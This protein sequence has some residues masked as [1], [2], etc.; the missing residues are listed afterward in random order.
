MPN[1]LV[2]TKNKKI[3]VLQVLALPVVIFLSALVAFFAF[4]LNVS[5]NN[6]NST[7]SLAVYLPRAEAGN[8]R[9][10]KDF[11]SVDVMKLTK[12]VV[13]NQPS[14]SQINSIVAALAQ[15][16]LKYIAISVPMDATADYPAGEKP[17][18]QTAEVFTREWADAIHNHG[19][20]VMWRGTF[21]GLEG[22]Y[23][24]KQLVGPNRIS[25]AAWLTKTSN[26]ITSHPAYFQNGDI[27]APMPER[28]QGIFQDSTSFLPYT[29]GIQ[30]NYANFFNSVKTVSDAAF[31]KIGKSV[32][33]GWTANNFS[34]VSSGWLPVSVYNTAGIISVDYYGT[35]H[36]PQEMQQNLT[37][38]YQKTHKQIYLQ[39]WSD[40][41][42]GSLSAT[43]R[44]AYLTSMYQVFQ[45][46]ANQGVLAG[47]NYWGGW[48]GAAESILQ[49]N[50]GG[51]ELNAEGLQLAAFFAVN[52]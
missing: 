29:G 12:D 25:A 34:E 18:P 49:K 48:P 31:A 3:H 16:N 35:T 2:F 46:L 13:T 37:A 52:K 1:N 6:Y 8:I 39:E 22:L 15:L 20:K 45:H 38:L 21:S 23:N 11:T 43:Q 5:L 10:L 26:Y 28:T 4:D 51:Y 41:W 47:F 14:Q 44:Q 33:T 19:L 27:W 42:D 40:Y 17:Y 30:T 36:T 50:F 24:F 9:M 32:I 7:L